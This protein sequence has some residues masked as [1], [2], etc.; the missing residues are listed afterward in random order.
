MERFSAAWRESGAP[1]AALKEAQA[2]LRAD[3]R[4]S[5]PYY[6]GAWALWGL[7]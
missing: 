6:W 1:A 3:K 7:E 2:A 5:D 4:W